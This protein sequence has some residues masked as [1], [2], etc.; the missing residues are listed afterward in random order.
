MRMSILAALSTL[1]F[2]ASANAGEVWLSMDRVLPYKLE[3]PAGKIVVGNAGIADVTIQDK[4][5][6]MLF[7]KSPGITNMYIFDDNGEVIENLTVSVRAAGEGLL[8]FQRGSSRT[9]Y[10]CTTLCEATVTIGDAPDTFGAVASQVQQKYQT[11]TSTSG[12]N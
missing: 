11:A 12:S 8:T 6:I 2:A 10:N 1:L 3:T 4:T 9:T 7:G 5:Q